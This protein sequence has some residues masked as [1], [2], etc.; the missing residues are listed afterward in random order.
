MEEE[1]NPVKEYL[2]DYLEKEKIQTNLSLENSSEL[3]KKIIS[4]C[5]PKISEFEGDKDENLAILETGIMHYMLTNLL[6]PSQRKIIVNDIELDIIVPD[7]RTLSS[8]PQNALVI[9]IPKNLNSKYIQDK[10]TEMLK[11]QPERKNIWLVSSKDLDVEQKTFILN[12]KSFANIFKEV[13]EFI[14]SKN[15]TA[16]KIFKN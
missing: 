7:T 14:S 6:I 12:Q 15:I 16:F 2:F 4:D 1:V 5:S 10:L 13:N 9:F 11:I 3:T 8:K